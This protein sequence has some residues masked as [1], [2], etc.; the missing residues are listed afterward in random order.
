ML[1]I[2]W[3]KRTPLFLS[4]FDKSDVGRVGVVVG[5]GVGVGGDLVGD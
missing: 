3:E 1:E 2:V 4:L 5:V